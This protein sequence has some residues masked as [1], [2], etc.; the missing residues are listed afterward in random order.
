M[1]PCP[2]SKC[3]QKYN[4]EEKLIKHLGTHRGTQLGDP[5]PR[6]N[7]NDDDDDWVLVEGDNSVQIDNVYTRRLEE[8]AASTQAVASV[9][10]RPERRAVDLLEQK[11][12]NAELKREEERKRKEDR[13]QRE[14]Q[15]E[16]EQ[17]R[18]AT[19]R[20][21]IEAER[22]QRIKDKP[23]ECAICFERHANAA[24]IP[25]GHAY[26]CYE[27][28]TKYQQKGCPFC[29]AKIERALRLYQ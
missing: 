10:E 7:T 15:E 26:F 17:Q 4:T 23:S 12:K 22:L 11:R 25:C 24:A 19:L 29:R 18:L 20:A 2:I 9:L 13:E 8:I 16:I 21:Q 14:R 28:L 27:C 3:N 5:T 6:I 1:L